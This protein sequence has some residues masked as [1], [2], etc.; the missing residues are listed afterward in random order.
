VL[1]AGGIQAATG[2]RVVHR[3]VVE[4]TQDEAARLRDLGAPPRTAVVAE[5]QTAGRGRK[6]SPF[7]SPRGGLY[8]S[9]LLPSVPG[10]VPGPA[11]AAV[12]LAVAEAIEASAGTDVRVK[13]PN[14]LWVRGKKVAG[15]LLDAAGEERPLLAG[16][17]INVRRVPEGL[18]SEDR[19]RTTALDAEAARPTSVPDLLEAL[20]RRVDA[21]IDDLAEP[22]GRREIE[23]AWRARLALVGERIRYRYAGAPR[24]GTL[25]EASL[26]G[27]RVRDDVEGD[28]WRRPEHVQEVR[29][30]GPGGAW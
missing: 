14:D 23:A 8:V 27:L 21:R 30:E 17:G 22:E 12:S 5:H 19:A 10:T 15:I 4:S 20:L 26:E 6:G 18:S 7:A 1:D 3:D 11:T 25:L 13:W 24:A 16:I 28:V 2:W 9:L 29:P